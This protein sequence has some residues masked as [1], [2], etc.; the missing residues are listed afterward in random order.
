MT[1]GANAY[2]T[3]AVKERTLATPT[4]NHTELSEQVGQDGG[5]V[6]ARCVLPG[7]VVVARRRLRGGSDEV[8]SADRWLGRQ[9]VAAWRLR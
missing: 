3:I 9:E 7:P 1:G 5:D 6:A 8:P 2:A 4:K